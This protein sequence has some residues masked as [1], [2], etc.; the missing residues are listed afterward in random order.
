VDGEIKAKVGSHVFL[1][2]DGRIEEDVRNPVLAAA[3]AEDCVQAL[4]S[5]SSITK[6]YRL[7]EGVAEA[8][9]EFLDVP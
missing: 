2:S 7:T 6:E 9:T 5:K 8:V 1:H 3:I 4:R